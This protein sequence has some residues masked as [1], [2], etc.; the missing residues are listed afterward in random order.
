[1]RFAVIIKKGTN[2]VLC[3]EFEEG[4]TD[5]MTFTPQPC[6]ERNDVFCDIRSGKI[7]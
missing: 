2:M 5:D 4:F 3:T 6:I 7:E 1:M